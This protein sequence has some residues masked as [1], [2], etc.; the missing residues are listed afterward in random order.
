M[1]SL[2]VLVA[3][4]GALSY[5]MV[6]D[7]FVNLIYARMFGWR[8]LLIAFLIAG[9]VV[10]PASIVLVLVAPTLFSSYF[11]LVQKATAV[12]LLVVGIGW[13]GFAL[14]RKEGEPEEVREA[15][16]RERKGRRSLA[17]ATQLVAIEQ[18]E[19]VAILIPVVITGHAIEA[20]S[21][22]IIAVIVALLVAL[23]LRQRFAR[24]VEGRFRLLKAVSGTALVIL[25]V[26]LFL[27]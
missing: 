12:I 6:E 15:E 17:L 21:A 9:A 13:L 22:G 26:V 23:M 18:V 20:A 25:G 8:T 7:N 16:G 24:L 1:F 3:A 14:I 2:V 11:P 4:L 5:E 19:I 27:S 10:V